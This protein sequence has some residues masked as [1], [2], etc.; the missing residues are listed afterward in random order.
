[1]R[2]RTT[3]EFRCGEA[4]VVAIEVNTDSL[5]IISTMSRVVVLTAAIYN[6]RM[7]VRLK[8]RALFGMVISYRSLNAF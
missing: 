1:V 2:G 5:I 3:D 7:D 8:M 6:S 4:R